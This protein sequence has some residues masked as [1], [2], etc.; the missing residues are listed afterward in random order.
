MI[1]FAFVKLGIGESNIER[2]A[3]F[4]KVSFQIGPDIFSFQDLENGIL[5]GNRKAPYSL[6][7]Q[8]SKGDPRLRM[9][10]EKVDCRIHFALNCGAAS[11]PPVKDFTKQGIDEELRI[12]SQAFCEDDGNVR[13][14]AENNVVYLSKIFG[15]YKKDF[16]E[17][18]QQLLESV[19]SFL[20]GERK[21]ELGKLL[22]QQNSG[23]SVKIKYNDYDWSTDASD[24]TV[25][26][27]AK[28]KCNVT[29]CLNML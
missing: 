26:S 2:H 20:R 5:R 13:I 18:N 17:S 14:D 4:N 19:L 1:K 16:G 3:F 23:K 12:V 25:F 9:S 10:M 15:W 6:F 8:F 11:C 21:E 27:A 22:D 28:L 29:R 24:Y 7:P